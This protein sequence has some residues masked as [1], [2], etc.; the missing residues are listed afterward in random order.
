VLTECVD[1]LVR[2]LTAEGLIDSYFFINYWLEGPHVRLRLRPV[3]EAA[4]AT[5]RERADAAIAEFLRVRPALFAMDSEYFLNLY[6]ILF[7]VEYGEEEK[8]K[9]VGPDGRM[10]L[11]P[12]NSHSWQEYE[13]EYGKYGGK[14][15]VALAEWHFKHS[16]DLVLDALRTTN[17]HV[18]TVLLGFAAQLMMTMSTVFL[19][20]AAPMAA[21]LERY[22][23]YWD[24]AVQGDGP[25]T[26]GLY[27]DGYQAMAD[28]LGCRF[29]TI[30]AAVAGEDVAELS[31]P[32]QR[33]LAHCTQLRENVVDLAVSGKLEFTEGR[34]V[35]TEAA[36]RRVLAPYLHMTNNRLHLTMRDEAY[37]GFLLERSLRVSQ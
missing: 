15:G 16:S 1:P 17:L 33:W 27:A 23:R 18:R 8:A 10:R 24:G 9:H 4:T 25:V 14:A 28:S 13:P 37:L 35:D 2:K 12:V 5:V 34:V 29:D 21:F 3:N 36:L 22:Y 19:G 30:R 7:D 26:K 20:E 31:E 6:N 32:V 11:Q